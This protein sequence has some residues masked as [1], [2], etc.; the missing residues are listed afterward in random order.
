V[1]VQMVM[2]ENKLTALLPGAKFSDAYCLVVDEPDIDAITAARCVMERVPAWIR[3]LMQLRNRFA[4][5]LDLKPARLALHEHGSARAG[6]FPVISSA[7]ERVVLGFDDK[8]LDFRIVVD[9]AK[10]D[11]SHSQITTTTLVRPRNPLGRAYLAVVL[12]FHRMSSPPCLPQAVR[13]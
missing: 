4:S 5:L 2:P 8:H 10:I 13:L 6:A 1:Q 9:V 11:V 3:A 7:P 12:P